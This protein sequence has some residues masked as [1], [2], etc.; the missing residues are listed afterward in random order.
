M[1]NIVD[2]IKWRGDLSFEQSPL[3]T[4]DLLLLSQIPMLN[5]DN[6]LTDKEIENGFNLNSVVNRYYK[7]YKN[8]Q[9]G[10]ILLGH[11]AKIVHSYANQ[12]R[13]KD[14][15]ISDYVKII[16]PITTTQFCALTIHL[17]KK[18]KYIVFS[19][20]DDTVVGWKENFTMLYKD[21]I[22]AQKLAKDYLTKHGIKYH[23]L[24]I[25]G[26]SKGGNLSIYSSV[27]ANKRIKNKIINIYSFDGPGFSSNL[28]ETDKY[29]EIKDKILHYVPTCSVIGLLLNHDN[30]RII[31]KCNSNGLLQHDVTTWE[32]DNNDL[33]KTDNLDDK[34]LHIDSTIKAL[35]NKLTYDEQVHFVETCFN[36]LSC[37]NTVNLIELKNKKR[38]LLS[39]FLKSP[40]KDRQII[41]LIIKAL[42]KDNI[43]R[44]GI[45]FDTL[46]FNKK[47]KVIIKNDKKELKK[48]IKEK[49]MGL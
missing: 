7:I 10:L 35:T 46:S 38:I 42:I 5:L 40:K 39:T 43:I 28:Y 37:D 30:D 2:Y 20:T 33:I 11:I 21:K 9:I 29:F 14:L 23:S 22:E 1:G 18:L 6:I 24:I 36:I 8:K 41:F 27:H 12:N 31:I 19:G 34:A 45:I 3:N 17:T 49:K 15:Y 26:H 47:K 13:Y 44:N 32:V 4:V 48:L 16:D 25:G